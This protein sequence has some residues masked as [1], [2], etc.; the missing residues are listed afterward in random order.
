MIQVQNAFLEHKEEIDL[1]YVFLEEIIDHDARLIIDPPANTIQS[2][3]LETVSIM[4]SSFFLMLYNCVESTVINCLNTIIKVLENGG[5]KYSD[6]SDDLQIASLAAYKYRI[7]ECDSKDKQNILLKEQADYLTGL[8]VVHLDV[9]SLVGSSSQGSFSGSLDSKEIRKLFARIGVDLND[10]KCEEMQRIKECRNK[11]AHGECS[12]R[13]YGRN[14]TIQYLRACKDNTLSFLDAL[15]NRVD[16]F[17]S[18][19]TYRR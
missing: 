9:K 15:I 5:C 14:L 17:I 12:F 1:F 19:K 7:E 13:E 16:D 2:I 11:L 10:L 4:K 8:A 6:I 3:K 18:N